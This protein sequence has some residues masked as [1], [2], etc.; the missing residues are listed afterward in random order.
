M[1]TKLPGRLAMMSHVS[2]FVPYDALCLTC[3]IP[4]VISEWVEGIDRPVSGS[5]ISVQTDDS[6]R[7]EFFDNDA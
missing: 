7:T 3:Y 5:L 2:R 6:G 4:A 1:L